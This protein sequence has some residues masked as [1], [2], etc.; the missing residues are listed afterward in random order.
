MFPLFFRTKL[1][2]F[3]SKATLRL[4]GFAVFLLLFSACRPK[5]SSDTSNLAQETSGKTKLEVRFQAMDGAEISF[6]PEKKK[7][8]VL[9]FWATW[10][11]PCLEEFPK[12]KEALPKL[13]SDSVQFI[14]ATEETL[15]QVRAFEERYKTGLDL[16]RM[17]QGDLA[18]FEIYALPTTL[19]YDQQGEVVYTKAG[20][21]D[22]DSLNTL[23]ELWTKAP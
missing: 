14:L 6:S 10:C 7:W 9:H 1:P 8:T 11:K 18:D 17:S 19:I 12:M 2:P 5:S 3:C 21:L 23:E 22:W 15:D 20:L 13:E 16:M 4:L